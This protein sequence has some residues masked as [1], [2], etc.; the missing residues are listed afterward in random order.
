MPKTR[1]SYQPCPVAR[2]LDVVGDRWTMLI[3]RDAFDG[4]S[5]FGDLQRNLGVAKN[6]LADRLQKLVEA[7]ILETRAASDGSSYQEYV[8]TETGEQLFPVLVALRQWGEKE[9]F[10]PS[11]AHS[12]LVDKQSGQPL[13][14]MLPL[15]HDGSALQPSDT[16]VHKVA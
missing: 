9:R 12:V 7:G 2:A 8:L 16:M 11:E 14:P 1:S 13:L 15:A 5:R 4:I 6:I 10:A 3:V